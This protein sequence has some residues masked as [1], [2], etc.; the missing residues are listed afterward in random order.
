MEL[1]RSGSGFKPGCFFVVNRNESSASSSL[2]TDRH[3]TTLDDDV[4]RRVTTEDFDRMNADMAALRAYVT[5]DTGAQKRGDTTVRLRV[6]HSNLRA[7]FLEIR[8]DLHSTIDSVKSKLMTH[9]GTNASAMTLVLRDANG[10]VMAVLNDASKKLGYYGAE[11]GMELHVVDEDP[12]SLSANGWLE[13]VSK[14]KKYVMSDEDYD[15]REGTYRRWKREQMAKD[16]SWTLEKHMAEIRGEVYVAPEEVNDDTGKE[17]AESIQ[18]GARCEV[19]PGAK[20]GVV[21]FVGR[22]DALPAGFW[23]GIE[24]DEPVGMN[25]GTVKGKKLFECS[26]GYGSLQRPKNVS[27][28]DYPP[29]DDVDFSEDEI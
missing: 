21:R 28:G 23:I 20:R 5:A 29:L 17:E 3:L 18:V 1:P 7:S 10:S 22:C 8:F 15:K 16:P 6:S 9:C 19:N 4:R 25:N 14:V 13:D 11:D 2:L 24:F 27:C 26:D 12:N